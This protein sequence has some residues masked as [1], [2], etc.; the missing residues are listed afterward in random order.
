MI[1]YIPKYNVDVPELTGIYIKYLRD[2][3]KRIKKTDTR[4]VQKHQ[5]NGYQEKYKTT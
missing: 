5:R 2:G 1:S 3:I 4:K